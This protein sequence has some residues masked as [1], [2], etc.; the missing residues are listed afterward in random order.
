LKPFIDEQRQRFGVEPIC[1][2]LQIAPSGYWRETAR[3]RD[4]ALC[5]ARRR[6][7]VELTAQIRKRPPKSS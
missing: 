2:V 1:R 3:S 4:P 7:D 5:P 6:R